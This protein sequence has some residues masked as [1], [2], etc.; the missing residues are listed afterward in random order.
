MTASVPD[1]QGDQQRQQGEADIRQE[2]Q[3]AQGI[4]V[5][6]QLDGQVMAGAE[7]ALCVCSTTFCCRSCTTVWASAPA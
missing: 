2:F 6:I 1:N 7:A 5:Q 3:N 4:A